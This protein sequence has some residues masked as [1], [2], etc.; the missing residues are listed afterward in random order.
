[1]S[2]GWQNGTAIARH[3]YKGLSKTMGALEDWTEKD[4]LE[5]LPRRSSR[6]R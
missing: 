2:A 3:E 4:R 6:L 1:M 5:A